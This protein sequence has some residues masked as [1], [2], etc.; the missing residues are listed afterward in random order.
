MR[1][2]LALW[3]FML[4]GFSSLA[5]AT[6]QNLRYEL[7]LDGESVGHREVQIR[8]LPPA[9]GEIDEARMIRSTLD[10]S[11]LMGR[12][13]YTLVSRVSALHGPGGASFVAS[14][15]ENGQ[16]REI[17]ARADRDGSW[18]VTALEAGVRSTWSFR[19]TEVGLTTMDM[20]DPERYRRL[21]DHAS[22]PVLVT[23]TGQVLP[24]QVAELGE[25]RI[26]VAGQMLNVDKISW[27]PEAGQMI[28]HYS[29]EGLLVDYRLDFM[30]MR[31]HARLQ[32]LPGERS[33]G[34][35]EPVL[36]EVSE[37]EL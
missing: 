4:L 3:I 36:G 27:T 23:E 34:G 7:L 24:G 32:E 28:L 29:D 33:W 22:N 15:E 13:S 35:F 6:D 2:L 12:N 25:A 19:R 21:L 16:G 26:E 20:F 37:E 14:V 9:A 10:L 1:A 17:Q 5:G 30:G 18:S 11:V 8:Y 31:L